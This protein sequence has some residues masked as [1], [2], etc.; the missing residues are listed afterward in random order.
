MPNDRLNDETLND[1]SSRRAEIHQT[2]SG[3]M[4]VSERVFK[5]AECPPLPTHTKSRPLFEIQDE[6]RRE[7]A[8]KA[9][10]DLFRAMGLD[11]TGGGI[12]FADDPDASVRDLHEKL[13]R[14]FGELILGDDLRECEV[15]C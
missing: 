2:D 10:G 8:N 6:K 12:R 11:R 14:Q 3:L 4:V 7:M 15:K 13:W 5:A 1:W 9:M